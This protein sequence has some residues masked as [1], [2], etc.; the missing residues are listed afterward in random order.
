MTDLRKSGVSRPES[1]DPSPPRRKASLHRWIWASLGPRGEGQLIRFAVVGAVGVGVNSAALSLL[2]RLAHVAL[3][4]SSALSTELAIASNFLLD[5]HWTF[6]QRGRSWTR[7]LKFNL[8]ALAG[9]VLTALTVWF[10]VDRLRM[11]Y[12]L[13]NVL[14]LGGSGALNYL[15]ST[16]WIWTRRP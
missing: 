5:N 15:L 8:T 11:H 12:L 9:L 13:A 7:F 6:A 14:A 1:S 3:P 2:Y 16:T 10:L 4:L